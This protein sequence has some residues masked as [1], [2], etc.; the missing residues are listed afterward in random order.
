MN[1][2]ST[3]SAR[4]LS[5]AISDYVEETQEPIL[6]ISLSNGN[7]IIQGIYI[8]INIILFSFSLFIFLELILLTS[9][10]SQMIFQIAILW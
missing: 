1:K 3:A 4:S 6:N 9:L 5:S 7:I 10:C 8:M 2:S